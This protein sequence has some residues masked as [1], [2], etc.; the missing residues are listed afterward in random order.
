MQPRVLFICGSLN[1]TTINYEI[2]RHLRDCDCRFTPF[3]GD[4][5]VNALAAAGL[6]DFTIL[7]G[8]ARERTERFLAA[9]RCR[10]DHRGSAQRYD[11]V[12]T[13]SDLIV[14]RNVE[15]TP[16]ILV[17]EGMVDPQ[18]MGTRLVR[19]LRLPRYLGN[20]AMAGLSHAYETFCVAS[21]GFARRFVENGVDPRKIAVTGIP[22]FDNVQ[23]ALQNDFPFHDYVLGATSHLRETFKYENRKAFIERVCEIAAGRPIIFKLHPCEAAARAMAEIE[24]YAPGAMVFR[25]GNLQEMIANCHCMVTRYSSVMLL[26]LAMGKRVFSDLPDEELG[27]LAPLQNGGASARRIAA[28]CRRTLTRA[29]TRTA[30][31]QAVG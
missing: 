4:G 29:A 13:C 5:M 31:L 8:E 7:G 30:H 12:V 23:G 3:Y 26:A 19:R 14:P 11:L 25:E 10:I 6:L 21:E 2:A 15:G 28:I 22:N 17:Q 27:D 20:T 9:R 1:Q 24:K 18:G 16:L